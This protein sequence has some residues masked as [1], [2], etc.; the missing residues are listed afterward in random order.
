MTTR[1]DSPSLIREPSSWWL[2]LYS[3]A[4]YLPTLKFGLNYEFS[5]IPAALVATAVAAY[6]LQDGPLKLLDAVILLLLVCTSA[7]LFVFLEPNIIKDLIFFLVL[8]G[9]V[10]WARRYRRF[11]YDVLV[12][13]VLWVYLAVAVI[14]ILVPQ[15]SVFKTYILTRSFYATDGLRGVSSLATEPSYYALV[16]FS[17]WLICYSGR[18]FANIPGRV[19]VLSL[20]SLLLTKSTMMVLIVPLLLLTVDS[21]YQAPIWIA[22]SLLA[23]T[24]AIV[25]FSTDSRATQLLGS[26]YAGGLSVLLTDESA[27][28]RLFFIVKDFDL[29]WQHGLLPLGPGSYDYASGQYDLAKLVPS[30]LLALYD[31]SMSGSLLGHFLVEYGV[32]VPL[33]LVW[34]YLQFAKRAGYVKAFGLVFFLAL[35]LLQMV[36]LVF[37]PIAFAIGVMFQR[38]AE[39]QTR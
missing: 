15:V 27:G 19:L 21:R 2:L 9:G 18:D 24:V 23:A 5:L 20:I 36:S 22:A 8:Y 10:I 6:L 7:S 1:I 16:V 34:L 11:N 29:S 28:S 13:A 30:G 14:E 4:F 26:L 25:G 31:F 35:L 12:E 38:V 39:G 3:V 32:F 33:L 17:C 37:A